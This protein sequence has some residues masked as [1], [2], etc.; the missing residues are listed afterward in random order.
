MI[1]VKKKIYPYPS[2]L[3][4]KNYHIF[5]IISSTTIIF[6][7]YGTLVK[8][9][10]LMRVRVGVEQAPCNEGRH[11]RSQTPKSKQHPIPLINIQQWST[12]SIHEV[13]VV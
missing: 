11:C 12:A 2:L 7:N 13:W 8:S 6:L 5:E 3:P 10:H 9:P 4:D 1:L